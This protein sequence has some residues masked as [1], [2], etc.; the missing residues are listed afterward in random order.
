MHKKY[1]KIEVRVGCTSTI[2]IPHRNR[3]SNKLLEEDDIDMVCGVNLAN[4]S[5]DYPTL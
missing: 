4:T 2:E 5:F 1:A 3:V